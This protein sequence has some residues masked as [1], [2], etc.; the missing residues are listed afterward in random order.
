MMEVGVGIGVGFGRGGTLTGAAPPPVTAPTNTAPPA[1]AGTAE[2]GM[3]LTAD[4]G[5]WTGTE[6]IGYGWQWK[7]AGAAIPGATAQ[8]YTLVTADVGRAMTVTVAADNAAGSATATSAATAP[9][10]AAAARKTLIVNFGAVAPGFAGTD[11]LA[12]HVNGAAVALAY[13]D[14]T[15]SPV[16]LRLD[17]PASAP[18]TSTYGT[19]GTGGR[20]VGIAAYD[21][22][23]YNDAIYRSSLYAET[24]TGNVLT[25]VL[26]GLAPGATYALS[27]CGSRN[28]S[29]SR[30]TTLTDGSVTIGWNANLSPA[31]APVTG[32]FAA[33]PAGT[34][35]L[36]MQNA[37]GTVAYLGGLGIAAG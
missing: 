19:S 23:L 5:T 12:S 25:L 7:R 11:I 1:I 18:S 10:T 33:G 2:E 31:A 8:G 37:S 34:I 26:S 28:A 13:D 3:V 36:T 16:S 20:S 22:T 21:G 15:P 14:G 4:T 9:V 32:R 6:P 35:T 30:V 27:A 29:G 17:H 24:S